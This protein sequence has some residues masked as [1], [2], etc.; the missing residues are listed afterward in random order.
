MT[1]S[2]GWL[3]RRDHCS[4]VL[5]DGS[6]VLMGGLSTYSE[7]NDVWR[8]TDQG[9][10]WTLMNASAGWPARDGQAC[11][12]TPDGS[13]VLMGGRNVTIG[14]PLFGIY[15]NDVWRSSDKGITWTLLNASAGWSARWG[16]SSVVTPDGS[17][18]LLAGEDGSERNDVWRSTD[19]G[20]TWAL[21][22]TSASWYNRSGQ[23]SVVLPD[24]SIVLMGGDTLPNIGELHDVWRSTDDGATWTQVTQT[25]AWSGRYGHRSIVTRGGS[26]V[27]TGGFDNS[28]QRK[29][30]VWMSMDGGTTWT[31]MGPAA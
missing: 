16:H 2:A 4:V 17:I 6:I 19:T 29:N 20:I 31:K 15:F 13:I 27:L 30:D 21:V 28:F 14:G 18:V 1:S 5:P 25:A 7:T 24:G 22:N 8:S 10:T 9:T 3:P 26:I 11:V 23:S 12:V